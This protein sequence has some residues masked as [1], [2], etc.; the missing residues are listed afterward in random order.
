MLASIP[1]LVACGMAFFL[2]GSALAQESAEAKYDKFT[3]TLKKIHDSRT[4]TLGYREG[5]FPFSYTIT[6]G[7]PPVG[8]SIDLCLAIAE[9]IGTEVEEDLQVKYELVTPEN[10]IQ[11]VT[12]GAVD[13][14]CGSTTNN[15]E[16]R[17]EVAFSPLIFVSGTKLAVPRES[18]WKSYRDMRGKTVV[19]TRGTT[20]EAA[21]RSISEKQKLDVNLILAS[22]HLESFKWFTEGKADALAL[23]D[24]LIYGLLAQTGTSKKYRVIGDYLS[25]DPYGI[26]FR[27]DEPY[28]NDVVVRTFRNLAESRELRFIYDRWF[29][30]RLPSGENLALPMSAQLEE[31]FRVLGLPEE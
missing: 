14:E 7:R 25:Y 29:R 13:L 28:L 26:M 4:I 15:A 11:K 10:R 24:V 1:W 9:E 12:S 30:R 19:A 16:R 2:G 27:K 31:N 23:D 3:G 21:V 6:K 18:T 17:K 8:Y 5:S 22:D 20:N